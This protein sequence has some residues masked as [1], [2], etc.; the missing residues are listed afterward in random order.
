MSDRIEGGQAFTIQ[1]L[2]GG[3]AV[4]IG[5]GKDRQRHK[6]AATDRIAAEAEA[7]ARIRAGQSGDWPVGRIV[8]AYIS[9]R[10]QAGIATSARQADAWKAMAPWWKAI[11]IELI[12]ET[13][14]RSYATRRARAAETVRYELNMLSVALRWA[15]DQGYIAKAPTIW[16]PARTSHVV[17]HISRDAFRRLLDHA[18]EPHA[19]LYM[20]LG[21]A[22]L[23]RPTALLE[24]TWDRVDFARKMVD[25]DSPGRAQSRK[26]RPAIPLPDWIM[27]ALEE[28]QAAAITD[29]VIERGGKP[30]ASIKKA[31]QAASARSGIKAT[32]YT[33][34]H[35]AAVWRAEEGIPMAE[36]AQLMGHA[37]STTTERHY[38]RFSPDHLRKAANAGRW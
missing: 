29:H 38:A 21:I 7:R 31:F 26:R 5:R 37:D 22:T 4:V 6:L 16:R 19:R 12:D 32:P 10:K 34:R 35:T 14:C 15:A 1:R 9:A 11:S 18:I 28:A 36:L 27:P 3:W 13:L 33:L 20:M 17:R 8:P 24:L 25:L 30:I 23:A 2:R